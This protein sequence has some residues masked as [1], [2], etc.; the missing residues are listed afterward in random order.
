MLV[1]DNGA[2]TIKVYDS[3]K[4]ELHTFKNRVYRDGKNYFLGDELKV[5]NQGIIQYCPM[6]GGAIEFW[7][8]QRL[9]WSHV[10]NSFDKQDL[11]FLTDEFT[12]LVTVKSAICNIFLVDLDFS[13]IEFLSRSNLQAHH[14]FLD[15]PSSEFC[16]IVDAGFDTTKVNVYCNFD[17]QVEAISEL[18]HVIPFG[19]KQVTNYLKNI[20]SY[21][22]VD[23]SREFILVEDIK[24]KCSEVML[25]TE[26]KSTTFLLPDF[27]ERFEGEI[28][29]SDMADDNMQLLNLKNEILLGPEIIF[30]P[31][32]VLRTDKPGLTTVLDSILTKVN[33]LSEDFSAT[34]LLLGQTTKI[35]N[36]K[37]RL[38]T[39][40]S[41][42]SIS[43]HQ[44]DNIYSYYEAASSKL[45]ITRK[46]YLKYLKF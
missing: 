3:E 15:N 43:I 12:D 5:K 14:F 33:C 35:K 24:L 38:K 25:E 18:S 37:N 11:I 7:D 29:D 2:D 39:D 45:K 32:S 30:D 34:C 42:H 6:Q 4:K 40:L 13:S 19:G 17:N 23:V 22:E 10:F 20:I 1:I 21:R 16:V 31:A 27:S 36:F 44:P 46:S 26:E 9:I 41:H 28:I 8:I